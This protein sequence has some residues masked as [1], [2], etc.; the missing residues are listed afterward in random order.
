[1]GT[2]ECG[3]WKS[4]LVRRLETAVPTGRLETAVP[5]RRLETG[6]PCLAVG[7]RRSLYSNW[8]TGDRPVCLVECVDDF[9]RERVMP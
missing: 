4:L 5:V 8:D 2:L 7:N 9:F 3:G 1:M 6:A